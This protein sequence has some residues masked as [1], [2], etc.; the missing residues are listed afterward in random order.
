MTTFTTLYAALTPRARIRRF[1]RTRLGRFLTAYLEMTLSMV[2]GMGL[3]GAVWDGV[4]PGLTSRPDAMALTMA[5]DMTLGMACWMWVR[6]HAARH[7]ASMSAVMV[8]PF[9][10]LLVPYWLGLVAGDALL[11]WGHIA[12]FALMAVYLAWR[13]HTPSATP[14]PAQK[15]L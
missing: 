14:P 13:P 5:F 3:F 9:L 8:L 2:V 7:I 15:G 10:V 11:T 6:G 1:L 12:M 4:W